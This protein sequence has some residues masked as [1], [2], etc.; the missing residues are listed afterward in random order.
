VGAS[1][2]EIAELRCY[3]RRW[4]DLVGAIRNT[5][6]TLEDLDGEARTAKWMIGVLETPQEGLQR[7]LR[8]LQRLENHEVSEGQGWLY[9]G[10]TYLFDLA[11]RHK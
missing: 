5:Y 10:L 1:E 8:V 11:G 7:V 6:R 3:A 4:P 2:F 9:N